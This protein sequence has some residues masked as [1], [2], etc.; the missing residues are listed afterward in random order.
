MAEWPI[1]SVLKTEGLKGSVGSNP[2]SSVFSFRKKIG[3]DRCP[4]G[5][6]LLDSSS[7]FDVFTLVKNKGGPVPRRAR[8]LK[9]PTQAKLLACSFFKRGN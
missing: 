1:A 3:R 2:T 6:R 4:S 7:N 5:H 8:Y 9:L